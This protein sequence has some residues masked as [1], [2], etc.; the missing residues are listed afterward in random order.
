MSNILDRLKQIGPGAVVAAAFIGPGTVTTAT[1]AGASYG[2]TLLWAIAFS[3]FATYILQEMSARLGVVSQM[4][5][6]QAICKKARTK[7][8][9]TLASVLIIS[10]IL[11]GN[12]AYEAGN[13]TGAALG[14]DPFVDMSAY[15][16]NPI[17][18]TIA[19]AAG[20][21]LYT[22][23]YR[24]IERSLIAMVSLMGVVFIISAIMLKP[25]LAEVGRGLFV[26]TAGE[27]SALMIIGLIGTTVV[28]Y[29]L[30][31]HAASVK[32]RWKDPADL[33][34]A[35]WDTIISV[36]LGGVITMAILITSSAA[37]AG[38]SGQVSGISDLALGLAPLLG[39]WSQVFIAFGFLA[40][41]FS[42]A[43]TA[44][45]AAS[46]ATSEVLNWGSDMRSRKFRLV[47]GIV[48]LCG[49]IFSSLGIRPTS[50]ILFAQVAN[51][52]LLPITAIFLLWIVNDCKIMGQF[53]N[54]K[55]VNIA[56]AIVIAVTIG[57][58]LKGIFSALNVL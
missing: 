55:A 24:L 5:V 42:S 19:I 22:G 26:P 56:G 9:R 23:K 14:F 43:V 12:A 28:P 18:L 50:L 6:G 20:L 47:W 37:F 11:V 21:L 1:I 13:I 58:G 33:E 34:H 51:G 31:L 25:P 30:F 3:I 27:G 32:K 52:L 17:V 46:F 45:L 36:L 40:A 49:I 8:S 54:S 15:R 29:N 38:S 7:T 4:G 39:D 44:P 35:R 48:L 10:A 53:V 41:G 16:V 57:L 2:Y